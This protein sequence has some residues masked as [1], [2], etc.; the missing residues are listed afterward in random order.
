MSGVLFIFCFFIFDC[1]NDE[2][3]RSIM[4]GALKSIFS[5]QELL[6]SRDMD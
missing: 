5:E 6:D 4:P 1:Q 3:F 2:Q